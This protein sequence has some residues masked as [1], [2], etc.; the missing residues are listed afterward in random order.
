MSLGPDA[1]RVSS[2]ARSD[3]EGS[4]QAWEEELQARVILKVIVAQNKFAH[5]Y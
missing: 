4:V 2:L 1:F 5:P 3:L